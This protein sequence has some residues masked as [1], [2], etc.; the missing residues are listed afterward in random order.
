M[1]QPRRMTQ[2]ISEAALIV[3]SILLAF[4]IDAWWDQRQAREAE[5]AALESLRIEADQNRA[6][7]DTIIATNQAD[8][9]RID[10]FLRSTGVELRAL[11]PDSVASWLGAISITWTYDADLS[12]THLFLDSSSPVTE[13]GRE[14]RAWAAE[15]T[16]VLEDSREEKATLWEL[17]G[18]LTSQ[19]SALGLDAASDGSDFVHQ[20]A[21]RL[22]PRVVAEAR[23]DDDFVS[24]TL[25]KSHYQLIYMMELRQASLVLDSLRDAFR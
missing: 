13:R 21:A 3:G 2:M 14:V 7:L 22:G 5:S 6:K 23:E 10:W 8:L 17:G 25:D 15:W 4:W 16:R 18:R 19:I 11:S 9:E 1:T 20:I 24:M 12:A